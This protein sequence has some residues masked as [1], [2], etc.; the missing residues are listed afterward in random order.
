MES[1]TDKEKL[2]LLATVKVLIGKKE[3]ATMLSVSIRTID[4]LIACHELIARKIGR[5]TLIPISSL[6]AFARRDH[7]TQD[8]DCHGH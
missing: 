2:E 8:E 5:R 4:N 1:L 6:E 3:V 7:A